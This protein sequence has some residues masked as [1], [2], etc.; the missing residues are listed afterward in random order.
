MAET[1]S[2][3]QQNL[4]ERILAFRLD[5]PQAELPFTTRLSREQAWPHVFAGQVIEEYKRFIALAMLAGHPVTPSEEVDQAWHLH[6][7]YTRS[8]WHDLCRDILNHDLHHGPT[9]GGQAEGKKF[10][11]WYSQTL[12]SYQRIFQ[13]DPPSDIWPSPADRF[14]N[15]GSSKW[16]DSNR[17]WILPKPAFL[18]KHSAKQ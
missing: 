14:V 12:A 17:F 18:Q 15:A 9:R 11:D 6:L 1:L 5:E 10:H 16:V 13:H 4:L 8:Y 7:V 2:P 3:E